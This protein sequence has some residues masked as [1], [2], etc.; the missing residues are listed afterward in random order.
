MKFKLLILAFVAVGSW[1]LTINN[2]PALAENGCP[3]GFFPYM[4]GC[5]SQY[6]IDLQTAIQNMPPS[7]ILP[8]K[9]FKWAAIAIDADKISVNSK[10]MKFIGISNQQKDMRTAQKLALK[11]CKSDGSNN[12]KIVGALPNKCLSVSISTTNPKG[13]EHFFATDIYSAQQISMLKCNHN[14]GNCINAYAECS[15]PDN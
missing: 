3:N 13:I 10:E 5:A 14:F 12:C 4:G 7:P 15:I 11:M 8:P 1:S 9:D 6:M 2:K